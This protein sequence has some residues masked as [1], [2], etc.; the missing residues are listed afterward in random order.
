MVSGIGKLI[1]VLIHLRDKYSLQGRYHV[2]GNGFEDC[3]IALI[4]RDL[5]P[6]VVKNLE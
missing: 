2:L 3:I 4:F 1:M 5:M 6:L